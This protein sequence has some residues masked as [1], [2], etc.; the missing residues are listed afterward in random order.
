MIS[1][2]KLDLAHDVVDLLVSSEFAGVFCR[3]HG[4]NIL[5]KDESV[6]KVYY[7]FLEIYFRYSKF[8]LSII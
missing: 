5:P 3:F 2:G 6:Y 8:S 4:C 7:K 1:D